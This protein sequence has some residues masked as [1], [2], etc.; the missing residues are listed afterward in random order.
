MLSI[1]GLLLL[2]LGISTTYGSHTN[3][4]SKESN[5]L[6]PEYTINLDLP[7]EERWVHI[8]PQYSETIRDVIDTNQIS[9]KIKKLPEPKLWENPVK[10]TKQDF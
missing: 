6:I 8:M 4:Y 5:E 1:K 2:F 10:P 3:M 7:P 9:Y